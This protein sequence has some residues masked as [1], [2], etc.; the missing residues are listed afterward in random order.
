[1]K[2]EMLKIDIFVWTEVQKLNSRTWM[3]LLNAY[4]S[5]DGEIQGNLLFSAHFQC[6]AAQVV[7][8]CCV[9]VSWICTSAGRIEKNTKKN[10]SADHL[11]LLNVKQGVSQGPDEANLKILNQEMAKCKQKHEQEKQKEKN[12]FAKMFAWWYSQE[13]FHL[14]Q[15]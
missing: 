13:L 6:A 10:F 11:T 15:G 1:M 7:K 4:H 2:G 9:A 3:I 12:K 5:I 14:A 8:F